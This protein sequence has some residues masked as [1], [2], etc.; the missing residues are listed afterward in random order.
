MSAC[1]EANTNCNVLV[2]GGNEVM[3]QFST[4]A[5]PAAL[6]GTVGNGTFHLTAVTTYTVDGGTGPSGRAF[7]Q[8]LTHN[9]NVVQI[10]QR[11]RQADGGCLYE[12]SS[13]TF[14]ASGTSPGNFMSTC[15]SGGQGG[16]T[17]YTANA[18]TL[19]I[20]NNE[21]GGAIREQVFTKQ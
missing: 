8:T 10:V 17:P 4:A 20:Y 2:P 18:T 13:G 21:Q 9:N 5:V 7:L 11:A 3:G 12:H 16:M 1:P 14:A 6:G 19:I 15:P